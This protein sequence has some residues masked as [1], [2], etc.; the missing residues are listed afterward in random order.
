MIRS[1]LIAA[2]TL[3]LSVP[4]AATTVAGTPDYPAGAIELDKTIEQ[5]YAYPEKLP[6]GVLPQSPLLAREKAAVSDRNS[7]LHYAEDRIQS[8]A[9]HHAITGSSFKDSWAVVPTY[10]DLWIVP[11]GSRYR[12]DAVRIDS[13]AERA[14]IKRGE[15]LASVNQVPVNQAVAA[16]WSAI[17]LDV[18]PRRAGFGARV[19]AAGRR[20]RNRTLG[21]IGADGKVQSLDLISLYNEQRPDRP[22]VSVSSDRGRVVIRINN[23]LGDDATIAAFDTAMASVGPHQPVMIDLRETPSGGNSSVARAIMGWFVTKPTSFQ[24]HNRP[25]EQRETGIAHQWIEQVLPRSGKFHASLPEVL[26]SRWT[27]SMGEGVAIGFDAMGARVRGG[28]MAGLNGSVEDV[29]LGNTDVSVKLPTER[30]STVA[31]QPREDFQP[32]Q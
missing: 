24:V 30:L 5:A 19:I 28:P 3:A 27:G 15:W 31:G 13:P 10:A 9:D 16:Y 22:P 12:I 2:S 32:N 29:A 23:S 4:A 26:V 8:L 25:I 1:L 7:L 11:D 21:I 6:G 18:T 20:D 14:G 17:G